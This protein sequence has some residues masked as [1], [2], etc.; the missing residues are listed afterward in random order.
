MLC[1]FRGCLTATRKPVS[2]PDTGTWTLTWSLSRAKLL[3]QWVETAP[4]SMVLC[5][6]YLHI[7]THT[8]THTRR[9]LTKKAWVF[10]RVL[11]MGPTFLGLILGPRFLHQG[12]GNDYHTVD[13]QNPA[14]PIIRN[15]P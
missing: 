5:N 15:I 9:N 10:I 8:H 13:G 4:R 3:T 12:A 7:R 1:P 14:L 6:T 2:S 11:Y